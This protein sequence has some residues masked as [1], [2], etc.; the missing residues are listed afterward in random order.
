MAGTSLY[1][2]I[3]S[4]PYMPAFIDTSCR[5]YFSLSMYNS[6]SQL[7]GPIT[8]QEKEKKNRVLQSA[9]ISIQGQSTNYTALSQTTYPAG[10]KMAE[11][12]V[13]QERTSDDKYYVIISN[14]DLQGGSFIPGQF[15]K[16]QIR[17]MGNTTTN[18]DWDEKSPY[19]TES[20]LM[21]NLAAFSEWSQIVLIKHISEPKIQLRDFSE[22][23]DDATFTLKDIYVSGTITFGENDK[24]YLKQYRI[25]ILDNMN[26]IIEDSDFK[27]SNMY[28]S[29]NQIS[30][31]LKYDLQN[32]QYY[33]LRIYYMTNNL[34]ESITDYEFF[35]DLVQFTTLDSNKFSIEAFPKIDSGI[36][37]VDLKG[38][39]ITS[40]LGTN[41]VI[42]RTSS[43]TN[44][45][46]WEDVCTFLCP[47]G[48]ALNKIWR[49]R[50]VQSGIWYKYSFQRRDANGFRSNFL[51]IQNP[52]MA[53][54]D[55]IYL[56][57]D[58]YQLKIKFDPQITNYS[59]VISQS[60][61]QTIGSKFP[62]IRRNGNVNYRTFTLTGTISHFMDT[63]E[64]GMKASPQDL[65]GDNLNRYKQWNSAHNITP[66]NDSVYERDFRQKVIKFL[67]E[68]KV[69]LYKSTTEGNMLVKLMNISFTP[70]NTLGRHIYSFTCTAYQIDQFTVEN[71]RK[72]GLIDS[73]S[74]KSEKNRLYSIPG[75]IASPEQN[76]YSVPGKQIQDIL[77]VLSQKF[78][79]ENKEVSYMKESFYSERNLDTSKNNYPSFETGVNI[80]TNRILPKYKKFENDKIK[81]QIDYLE[82]FKIEFTSPPYLIGRIGD[83]RYKKIQP[84]NVAYV[85]T[86][87]GYN[88]QYFL[89]HLIK[90]NDEQVPILVGAD[91][92]YE[93]SEED[94][95]ITSIKFVEEGEKGLITYVAHL[96]QEPKTENIPKNYQNFRRIGQLYD[97]FMPAESIYKK[98]FLRYKQNK[99]KKVGDEILPDQTMTLQRI[100]GLRITTNPNVVIAVREEQD[101]DSEH[102]TSD[103][104]DLI[105]VGETGLI[106]FYDDDT[107]IKGLYILGP[108]LSPIEYDESKECREGEYMVYEGQEFSSFDE[109]TNP[110]DKCVYSITNKESLNILISR[111]SL[112]EANNM[113]RMTLVE[114][115]Q[116]NQINLDTILLLDKLIQNLSCIYYHGGWYTFSTETGIV[117]GYPTEAIIDYYCQILK[118]RY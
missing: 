116:V 81:I 1:P 59:H 6:E 41:Y 5:I 107:N 68:N 58:T 31:K 94:T 7:R 17:L 86:L 2:P 28:S 79:I 85:D 43:E 113:Y 36:I 103:A 74:Y 66:Y 100:M 55:D 67:Y 29:V 27:Y 117:Y 34:Y 65:Y 64:N 39:S 108:H 32:G 50:T 102:A 54:F 61:T 23:V 35:V 71:C 91:G 4:K 78:E 70:N 112:A 8:V 48:T 60:S 40:E 37:E 21:Q 56:I 11:I 44:F 75:Q 96:I 73:G 101:G 24:E 49:D 52:V 93:L 12:F 9:Q 87:D 105:Q 98:I 63:K 95:K 30:Y 92:I 25:Y 84:D 18:P 118:E 47:A 72:Y 10:I 13:D 90:I 110:K 51:Q 69:K 19:P 109:I 97:Y 15:Y 114:N 77:M 106:E 45:K 14:T 46:I 82:Y 33:K 115:D 53:M 16:V 89:G 26:K 88:S 62:F 80:I 42:R 38:T 20:W 76:I 104:Y 83:L 3:F 57:D 99:T 111:L 22:K